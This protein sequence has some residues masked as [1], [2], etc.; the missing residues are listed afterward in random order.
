MQPMQRQG[1]TNQQIKDALHAVNGRKTVSFRLDII[2][3][4][5]RVRSIPGDGTVTLDRNRSIQRT[6]Q[7]KIFEEIDW[8]KDQIKPYMLLQMPDKM[9]GEDTYIMP[10][11]I[12]DKLNLVAAEFDALG[13]TGADLEQGYIRT[14]KRTEQWAEFPL[15]IFMPISHTRHNENGLQYW[16]VEAYDRNL[17]LKEDCVIDRLFVPEGTLY[18][19]AIGQILA[20]AGIENLLIKEDSASKIP[21]DREFDIGTSK[22]DIINTM[23]QEIGYNDIHVNADGTHIISKYREP[24]AT[25]VVYAYKDDELSIIEADDD[26]E[27]DF[28]DIPNVIISVCENPETEEIYRSV[29]VNDKP[30]SVLSTVSRGRTVVS[31]IYRPDM[32]ENQSALDEYNRRIAFEKNQ[33]YENATIRTSPNPL[34]EI[35][36][37]ILLDKPGLRG[38]FVQQSW[39]ITLNHAT[40]M[41]HRIKRLVEL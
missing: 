4:G 41:T 31:E 6:A 28:Y 22:L 26:S 23:L 32:I 33:I 20:G 18:I 8:I 38:V 19:D 7:F 15:G 10:C 29:W 25:D 1:F 37:V 2:R 39:T 9:I 17:I 27:T 34:H 36:D 14:S 30:E 16:S 35:G 3:G 11:Y 24:S 40:N 21:T 12:F 5:A 13:V